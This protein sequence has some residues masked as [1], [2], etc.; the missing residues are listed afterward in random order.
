MKTFLCL[1][2]V[3][4][5]A[6]SHMTIMTRLGVSY[7]QT[8]IP[9]YIGIL[10][11]IGLLVWLM[12]KKFTKLR[13]VATVFS[14][15]ILG[16]FLWYT[17]IFSAIDNTKSTIVVGEVAGPSMKQIELVNINGQRLALGEIFKKNKG[18]AIVFTRGD[19]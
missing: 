11:G 17:A 15:F 19:W 2:L 10:V 18:T 8:P 16:F 7:M 13:L 4:F 5:S 1:I 3:V 14:V 12:K 9:H 6:V